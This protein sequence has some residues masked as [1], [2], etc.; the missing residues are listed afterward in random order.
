ML[1]D[2]GK[3]V[4]VEGFGDAVQQVE[5]IPI[6]T[7]AVAC[8]CPT[9]HHTHILSFHEALLIDGMKNHLLNPNQFRNR[10]LVVNEVPLQH[11]PPAERQLVCHSI[12]CP[13]PHLHIPLTLKGIMSGFE[14]RLPTLEETEDHEERHVTWV[15]FTSSEPWAVSYTHLTLPTIL[16]V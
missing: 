7:A 16:L 13:D 8:D 2:T 3:R 12:V 10:G 15:H 4:I 14:T 9:A 11:L 6:V 1:Q 5:G